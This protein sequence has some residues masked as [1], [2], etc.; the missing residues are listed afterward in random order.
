MMRL[1]GR[2]ALVTGA[3]GGIGSAICRAFVAEGASV[4]A[5]DVAD[6]GGAALVAQLGPRAAY[7]ALDVASP[8]AWRRVVAAAEARHGPLS[9]LVNNAG[10]VGGGLIETLDPAL[11]AQ[12]LAVNLGGTFLGMQAALPS[13]RRAGGGAIVNVSSTAGLVGYP[14]RAAYVA[15][16]WGVRGLT[17][18]AALEFARDHIRV[19]SVHPGPIRT[20]LTAG[21][22]EDSWDAQAIPR[23]GE[24]AE[25]ARM[26]VFIVAE[27][28]YSTATEFVVDGGLVAGAALRPM[29]AEFVEGGAG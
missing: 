5:T 16:K 8:A 3:A 6:A 1:A 9:I 20:P 25:V 14:D 10:I 26:V 18:T 4:M 17:K 2:S 24:P 15:S 19:N 28:T 23:F 7:A 13:L 29:P 11:W 12:V 22:A 27:A 21:Y